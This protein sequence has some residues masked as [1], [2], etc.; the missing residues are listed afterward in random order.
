LN[1][2]ET[3]LLGF[4]QGG[5]DGEGDDNIVGVLRCAV[6]DCQSFSTGYTG[7]GQG[8]IYIVSRG[9]LPGV[10]WRSTELSLSVAMFVYVL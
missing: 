10:M 8:S 5:A 7:V 4:C 1:V 9:L 6:V 2:L 3:S